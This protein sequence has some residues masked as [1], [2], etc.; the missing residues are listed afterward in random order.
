MKEFIINDFNPSI[1]LEGYTLVIGNFDGVHLGHQELLKRAKENKGLVAVMTFDPH[2]MELIKKEK[3]KYLTPYENK[4]KIFEFL[5]VDLLLKMSFNEQFL[6]MSKEEFIGLLKKINTKNIVCGYDFS[7]GYK[8]S[9]SPLDLAKEFNTIVMPKYCIQ[10]ERVA[11]SA[12]R[13]YLDNGDILN[14]NKMLGRQY[15][16]EGIVVHG[17]KIG[18][19]IGFKTANIDYKDFYLPKNGV[20]LGKIILNDKELY[21]M[22]NIG[23]NPTIN[24]QNSIRLEVNIFEFDVDIYDENLKVYFIERIR[25]EKKFSSKDELI[26]ELKRNRDFG[27][28]ALEKRNGGMEK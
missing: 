17:N 9:G 3:F 1:S 25:D 27:I 21:G 18:R 4:K 11:S 14:A 23:Y 16:V 20:Y 10:G 15:M 2:P 22:I 6:K 24:L 7:F 5:N 8:G 26:E 13:Q 28:S 12:I 19:Q